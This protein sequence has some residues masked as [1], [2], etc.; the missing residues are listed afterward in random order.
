MLNGLGKGNLNK[1]NILHSK[2]GEPSPLPVNTGNF[3]SPPLD[4]PDI[5]EATQEE[6]VKYLAEILVEAFLWEHRNNAGPKE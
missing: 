5:H 2:E 3:R 4:L 1:G 6:Q